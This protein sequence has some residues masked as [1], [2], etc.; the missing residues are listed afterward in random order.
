MASAASGFNSNLAWP[1]HAARS[2]RTDP[3]I[4]LGGRL[5]PEPT[6]HHDMAAPELLKRRA[7]DGKVYQ[8]VAKRQATTGPILGRMIADSF[9]AGSPGADLYHWCASESPEPLL[10]TT[11]HICDIWELSGDQAAAAA[12]PEDA[13]IAPAELTTAE[14]IGRVLFTEEQLSAE[15]QPLLVRT[16]VLALL[17]QAQALEAI[18]VLLQDWRQSL[19]SP[20]PKKTYSE[21]PDDQR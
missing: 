17:K 1:D 15:P 12:E 9:A 18:I 10:K 13:A 7:A 19:D 3:L 6:T 5:E 14:L 4:P 8:R 20:Q 11:P 21:S 2:G 16:A